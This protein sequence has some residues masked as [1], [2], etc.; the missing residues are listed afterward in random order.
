MTILEPTG[1]SSALPSTRKLCLMVADPP[2]DEYASAL[3]ER[4]GKPGPLY[5]SSVAVV[6]HAC[7]RSFPSTVRLASLMCACAAWRR[8]K[9]S[10]IRGLNRPRLTSCNTAPRARARACV[11]VR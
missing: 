1:I 3:G 7:S 9:R 11:L 5:L 8:G 6:G 2:A 10:A 4:A